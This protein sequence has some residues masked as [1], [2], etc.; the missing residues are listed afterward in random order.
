MGGISIM[1]N[2]LLTKENWFNNLSYIRRLNIILF[3]GGRLLY[4]EGNT[5][6]FGELYIKY[7]PG[8][9]LTV[10]E[11]SKVIEACKR[12]IKS[13]E[14][15]GISGDTHKYVYKKSYNKVIFTERNWAYH[16]DKTRQFS[17]TFED[18]S[19]YQGIRINGV[20]Y[21]SNNNLV[22]FNL[23][24]YRLVRKAFIEDLDGRVY[25]LSNCVY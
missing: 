20:Y 3:S 18:G 14:I 22:D 21:D 6:F 1:Y 9:Y 7:G 16:L 8:G 12:N 10:F 11:L 23:I 15:L 4:D 13:V 24:P 5:W 2:S 17:L 19:Q 25:Q